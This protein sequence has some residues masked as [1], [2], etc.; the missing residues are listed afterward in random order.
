MSKVTVIAGVGPGNG[1]AFARRFAQGGHALGLLARSAQMV[2]GLA[3][4]LQAGGAQSLGVPVDLTD[5]AAVAD[6]FQ[7]IRR[8]LGDAD[9]LIQNAAGGL[10]APF[11]DTPVE[12]YREGF[13]LC[14]MAMVHCC[15]AVLPA[16]LARGAG[17]IVLSGATAAMRGSAGFSA[18]A[19]GKFGQR[20][21]AQ[22]LAREFGPQGVHVA[23]VNI[24]GVIG[25]P[26]NVQRL[27]DKPPE[28]FLQPADI[29]EA[30]WTL[31]EQPRSAWSQEIDLRPFGERF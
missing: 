3:A 30:Y 9:V 31:A 2:E 14:V 1:A 15:R 17:T 27:A 7:H 29:A 11:L 18:F 13:E 22:S 6:A 20:A 26:R 8:K 25:T 23:H 24:D 12:A 16:M 5:A 19:V 21:L 10:R 28:F 4:E